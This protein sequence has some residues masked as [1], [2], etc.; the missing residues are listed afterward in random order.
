MSRV[1]ALLTNAE[2]DL[3]SGDTGGYCKARQRLPEE[4][5]LRLL[6][7]TA[8]GLEAQANGEQRE[9]WS[10]CVN[11]GRFQCVDGRHQGKSNRL[12]TTQQ[13]GPWMWE[14]DCQE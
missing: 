3:P 6:G 14:P 12:S 5:R 7:K 8:S 9:V 11:P 4:L 10:A 13:S 2:A 1:K